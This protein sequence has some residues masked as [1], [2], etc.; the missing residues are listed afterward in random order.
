M[1]VAPRRACSRR[2]APERPVRRGPL[3]ARRIEFSVVSSARSVSGRL[4]LWREGNCR[5]F[6]A[7]GLRQSWCSSPLS[8]LPAIGHGSSVGLHLAERCGSASASPEPS[9][10]PG[11][12]N[13]PVDTWHGIRSDSGAADC[14]HW[15]RPGL[16]ALVAS[17][18]LPGRAGRVD[19]PR[20]QQQKISCTRR[21]GGP[22][23]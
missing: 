12:F 13:P 3:G 8:T 2:S 10:A 21:A 16:M 14:F 5:P 7:S 4:G 1:L 20:E 15:P 19:A 17:Q 9:E 22:D 11:R 18:S 6:M 23:C